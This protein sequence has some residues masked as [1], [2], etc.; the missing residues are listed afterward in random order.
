MRPEGAPRTH[1]LEVVCAVGE[2]RFFATFGYSRNRHRQENVERL[3]GSFLD[4]L[5]LLVEIGAEAAA[6]DLQGDFPLA[7]LD[8][9]ELRDLIADL[10][11]LDLTQA[12]QVEG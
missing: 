1:Q 6:A 10:D 9:D 8:D 5:R 4:R 2:G 7:G 3:A 11:A 12:G